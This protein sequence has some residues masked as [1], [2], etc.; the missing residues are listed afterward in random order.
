MDGSHFDRLARDL[1][2][3]RSRR[4]VAKGLAG[5]LMVGAV[6]LLA[7]RVTVA[8]HKPEHCALEGEKVLPQKG[9]CVGLTAGR[10][11][12]CAPTPPPPTATPEPPPPP[13]CGQACTPDSAA[14]CPQG[15]TC[16]PSDP[17]GEGF[18]CG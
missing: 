17:S 18:V 15:C 7:G 14:T 2:A 8:D 10:D 12:R 5:G 13:I 11:G 1:G 4:A 9:C 3:A 16:I 6:T